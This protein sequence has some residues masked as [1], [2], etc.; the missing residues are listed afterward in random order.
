MY[1]HASAAAEAVLMA[2]RVK[3]GRQR[4]LVPGTINPAHLRVMETYAEPAGITIDLMDYDIKTGLISL[5]D[6]SSKLD[7]TAGVYIEN[8]SYL[9]HIETQVQ[10]IEKITHENDSLFV[11]GVDIVSL[12]VLSPPGD[13]GADIVVGEG[14]SLGSPISYGG[15]LLGI[16]GCRDDMK[17]IRQLP[18]R[19]VG[20]TQT[21]DAPYE[22]GF[23]LTLSPREQHIRRE[24]A[25]SNICSNQALMAVTAAVHMAHLGPVGLRQLSETVAY[26]SHYVASRL[27]A[28]QGVTAPAIGD[29]FWKDFVVKFE[30]GVT[31]QQVH[32]VL[33][34]HGIHGGKILTNEYPAL[35]ESM[36]MSVTEIHSVQTIDK[37]ISIV[38]Q[39]VKG[40]AV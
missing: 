35:G 12:G 38:E 8:P 33:R 39:T 5:T 26:K 24:R 10:E 19:L 34:T 23:V 15:P 36:L 3:K 37:L 2:A 17:L 27:N 13:Y 40:G 21:K 14:Q 30:S 32:D 28:I 25:T 9:G 11:A 31:A 22:Q 16:F 20:M 29:S 4:F 18:G 7:D 1:D 6:L